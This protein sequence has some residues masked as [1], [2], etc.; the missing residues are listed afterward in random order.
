MKIYSELGRKAFI[1]DALCEFLGSECRHF[2][3]DV[4]AMVIAAQLIGMVW[5]RL[6]SIRIS[7][8]D[9]FGALEIISC[10]RM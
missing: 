3:A 6:V 8:S 7:S 5:N 10:R 4:M 1:T 2:F 9:C